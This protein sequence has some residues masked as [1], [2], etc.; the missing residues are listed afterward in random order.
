MNIKN[1]REKI[2]CNLRRSIKNYRTNKNITLQEAKQIVSNSSNAILIDVR[3]KQEYDEYHIDGAI[4]IPHYEIQSRIK[5]EIPNKNALII[6]YCQSG[7]RSERA[8]KILLMLGYE[9]VYHVKNG[10]DG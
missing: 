6:L 5:K 1:I 4:C 3:S 2:I 8:M 10:L 9:N 7:M